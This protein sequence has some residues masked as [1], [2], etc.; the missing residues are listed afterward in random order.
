MKPFNT[1][2]FSTWMQKAMPGDIRVYY[3][4]HWSADSDR[5]RYQNYSAWMVFSKEIAEAKKLA[6]DGY[7][8]LTQF[9]LGKSSFEYRATRAKDQNPHL[10]WYTNSKKKK[11]NNE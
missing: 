6:A 5:I 2:G 8:F 1:S 11:I 9:R 4:G 7:V 10:S 3:T